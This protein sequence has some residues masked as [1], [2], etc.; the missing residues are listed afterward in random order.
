MSDRTY[1]V[2]S[3]NLRAR[4]S[5]RR[6]SLWLRV[7]LDPSRTVT[8]DGQVAFCDVHGL[9]LGVLDPQL[10]GVRL[11]LGCFKDL[12]AGSVDASSDKSEKA[13]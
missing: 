10:A 13:S 12:L 2:V 3:R 1:T 5:S 9:D 11:D 8:P 7:N 4:L 6:N